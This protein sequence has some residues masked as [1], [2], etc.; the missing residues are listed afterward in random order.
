MTHNEA[1]RALDIIS[2]IGVLDRDLTAPLASPV[3]GARYIGAAAASGAWAG[4]MG[5]IPAWQ[6]G[7]RTS[8][9][10]E[11]WLVW[12]ADEIVLAAWNG[13]DWLTADGSGGI[14]SLNPA[15]GGLVGV[16]VAA[17]TTPC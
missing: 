2:Q 14:T 15:Q 17:D 11:G 5:R 9:M 6:D 7:A 13:S 4:N 12:F 3:E 1:I 10:R 16:N 8:Y